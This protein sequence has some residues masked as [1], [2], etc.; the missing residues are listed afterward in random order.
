MSETVTATPA[1]N[2]V[3]G[4]WH[5][6]GSG[7]TYEKRNPWRPSEVT[8]VFQASGGRHGFRFSYVSPEPAECHSPET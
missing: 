4:E 3:S 8:G 6:A 1:R 2:Y 5:S 7:E